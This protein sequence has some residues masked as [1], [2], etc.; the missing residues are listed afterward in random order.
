LEIE[1]FIN[2]MPLTKRMSWKQKITSAYETNYKKLLVIPIILLVLA[3]MQI[4]YQTATTGDFVKKGVSLKGGSI[5]TVLKPIEVSSLQNQIET[6]IPEIEFSFRS[7]TEAGNNIGISIESSAQNQEEISLIVDTIKLHT[8]ADS[9]DITIEVTGA[10]VGSSFFK[11]TFIALMM[12]FILMAVVVFIYFRNPIPSLA[13]ILAAFSDIVITIAIFNLTGMELST[14]G[15]AAFLMLVGYS[16]DTDI[17]LT[18]RVLRRREGSV[19][20]RILGAMRTGLMMTATTFVAVIVALMV[21]N[22]PVVQQIMLILLIGL[23]VDVINTWLQNAAIIRWYM[24][25]KHGN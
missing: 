18:S 2:Q 1:V 9:G 17:L 8:Q 19:N 7:I 3:F 4:G 11:Q 15:I 21:T 25:R 16:V 13:V 12:A 24:E 5:I 14:A 10:T 23:I 22:S 6:A 20:N